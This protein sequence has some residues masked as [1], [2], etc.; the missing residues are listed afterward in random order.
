[1]K[2]KNS[3]T[4]TTALF[5]LLGITIAYFSSCSILAH[6]TPVKKYTSASGPSLQSLGSTESDFIIPSKLE[7]DE[8]GECAYKP[9]KKYL[10]AWRDP[11]SKL[12]K[13]LNF[14]KKYSLDEIK[15]IDELEYSGGKY[16]TLDS[17]QSNDAGRLVIKERIIPVVL[18]VLRKSNNSDGPNRNSLEELFERVNDAYTPF[19]FKF[20]IC[21]IKSIR[22]TTL[23][24]TSYN[25]RS[26]PVSGMDQ[27]IDDLNI[28]NRNVPR[29]LNIYFVPNAR[30]SWSSFPRKSAKKQHIIMKND[31]ISETTMIHEI[32]HWFDLFHTFQP[33][34]NQPEEFVDGTNCDIAG[35]LCCDTHADPM[36]NST[37]INSSCQYI[38][39]Q[40]DTNGDTY[41]P[42]PTNYMSY[43]NKTCRNNFTE[44]Q[45]Y[46]MHAA[47]LGMDEER[48]YTLELCNESARK[49]KIKCKSFDP[50][51][52]IVK[53]K[54][55]RFVVT[56]GKKDL[57]KFGSENDATLAIET[58]LY[59]ELEKLCFS[60]KPE[61]GLEYFLDYNGTIPSGSIVGDDCVRLP[62]T[63]D[64]KIKRTRNSSFKIVNKSNGEL[65]FIAKTRAEAESIIRILKKYNPEFRCYIGSPILGMI[66]LRK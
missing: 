28:T 6:E 29:K 65:L 46:R 24:N 54:D 31:D 41:M 16:K 34:P 40:T 15:S 62:K 56:D 32:G 57:M 47:Y 30:T 37:Q 19:A 43:G 3:I 64:L 38:G 58:I 50:N 35:D 14:V 66:Y 52:L 39:N 45:I 13:R 11:N 61:P 2:S 27:I 49:G 4:F 44:D 8:E 26:T 59:Y 22:N 60:D 1:M 36:M 20:E 48:G 42:D 5:A 17:E 63:S 53:N 21:E 33:Q 10:K 9:T 23:F 55:N 7:E 25:P 12:N 18:H 51:D